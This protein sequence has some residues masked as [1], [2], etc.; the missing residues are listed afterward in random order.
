[1]PRDF[2]G[3][4]DYAQNTSWTLK[5]YP[6]AL[7]AWVKADSTAVSGIVAS[8]TNAAGT[9]RHSIAASGAAAGDPVQAICTNS[10]GTSAVASSSTGY[11]TGTW[12]C[13]TA[14]LDASNSRT[15][16]LN[17]SSSGTN[18]SNIAASTVDRLTIG[19]RHNSGAPQAFFDGQIAHVAVWSIG[20]ASAQA[21]AMARGTH[22]LRVR[23]TSIVAYY[24]ILGFDS[25]ENSFSPFLQNSFPLTLTGTT[26]ATGGPPVEPY[27]SRFWRAYP[28]AVVVASS[29]VGR[30][31]G[32]R[33]VGP[34]IVRGGLIA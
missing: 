5:D 18:T 8:I 3:I 2:N 4:T 6:L 32:R 10:G 15:V 23:T 11:S 16:W 34:G 28:E 26:A 22:P 24:S 21:L 19:A 29:S 12:F 14:S 1:M 30:I 31:V 33:P 9:M 7:H 27:R 25:P 17:G 20:L 13:I